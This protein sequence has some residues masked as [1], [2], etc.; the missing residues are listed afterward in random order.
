MKPNRYGMKPWFALSALYAT[1]ALGA[2]PE[3]PLT[4]R[5]WDERRDLPLLPMMA[6]HQ[7][8]SMRGHLQAVRDIVSGLTVED[9]A[10]VEK[11]GAALGF[12]EKMGQMCQNFGRAAPDFTDQALAFHHIADAIALAAH[13]HDRARVMSAL[14]D[15]LAACTAC[16][17]TWKQRIVDED[18]WQQ[19]TGAAAHR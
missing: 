17:A 13:D 6:E 3:M 2:P 15:T 18:T 5:S 4:S 12:S 11:A 14:A 1:C 9:Y 10:A 16:H 7:K 19:L 8:Q